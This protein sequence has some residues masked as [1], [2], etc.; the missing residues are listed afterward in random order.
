MPVRRQDRYTVAAPEELNRWLGR[1]SGAQEPLHIVAETD[2]DLAIE[3]RR[4]LSMAKGKH[5]PRKN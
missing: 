3:L 2:A 4:S 5:G 1:E